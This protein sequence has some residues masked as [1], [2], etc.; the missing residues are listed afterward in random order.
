MLTPIT[1]LSLITLTFA[2]TSD[3]VTISQ[4]DSLDFEGYVDVIFPYVFPP[5]MKYIN[6]TLTIQVLNLLND[7]FYVYILGAAEDGV[8]VKGFWDYHTTQSHKVRVISMFPSSVYLTSTG[9]FQQC[10]EV[11]EIQQNHVP[12]VVNIMLIVFY[13]LIVGVQFGCPKT[14]R[15]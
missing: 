11:P 7:T 12:W 4:Y 6:S 2:C 9:L 1:L 14:N 10:I 5:D 8:M 3:L 13:C 15:K